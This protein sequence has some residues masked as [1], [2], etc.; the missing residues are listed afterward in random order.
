VEDFGLHPTRAEPDDKLIN[1]IRPIPPVMP[2]E[3]VRHSH[4]YGALSRKRP[5]FD[6]KRLIQHQFSGERLYLRV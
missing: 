4:D 5:N 3:E 1:G 6:L 2:Y